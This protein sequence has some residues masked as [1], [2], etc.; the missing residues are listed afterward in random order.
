MSTTSSA[1]VVERVPVDRPVRRHDDDDVRPAEQRVELDAVADDAVGVAE[2]GDMR[3]V[4]ADV[5][6]ALGEAGDDVGGGRVAV[7]L[8]VGLEGDADDADRGALERPAAVV[9]RLGDEID[10]VPRH[11]QVDVAGEL[12]EAV[13]EVELARPPR[14]VVRID[15]DAV[16]ADARARA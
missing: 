8:D 1:V 14:Q 16:A 7:V 15:R 13:D 9:E 5:G 4:E 2:R 11:G 12:D 3:V 6:A 10:H